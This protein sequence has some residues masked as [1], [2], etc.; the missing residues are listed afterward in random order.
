MFRWRR[1][2]RPRPT[3]SGD[4]AG[5]FLVETLRHQDADIFF[6]CEPILV[7]SKDAVVDWQRKHIRIGS[8]AGDAVAVCKDD[9]NFYDDTYRNAAQELAKDNGVASLRFRGNLKDHGLSAFR[10]PLPHLNLERL[11]DRLSSAVGDNET[12]DQEQVRYSYLQAAL[13]AQEERK[14]G[15]QKDTANRQKFVTEVCTAYIYINI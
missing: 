2:Q 9:R 10:A 12:A 5:A 11:I 14:T 15:L 1:R 13:S 8:G 4:T 3:F 7:R 6:V